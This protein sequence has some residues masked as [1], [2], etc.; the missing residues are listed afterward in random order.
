MEP[1]NYSVA[2]FFRSGKTHFLAPGSILVIPNYTSAAGRTVR[3][4][5]FLESPEVTRHLSTDEQ[6]AAGTYY[7]Y[8]MEYYSS[9][10]ELIADEEQLY[11]A[12]PSIG[13]RFLDTCKRLSTC[14]AYNPAA[15][16]SRQ[17]PLTVAQQYALLD[18]A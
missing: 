10:A 6:E 15:P 8:K 9:W 18:A 4:R 2:L 3:H 13:R 11:A 16:Y 12:D 17:Q 7:R 14:P 5:G 1:D